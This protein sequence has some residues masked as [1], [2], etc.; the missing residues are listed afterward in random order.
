[1]AVIIIGGEKGGTGKSTVSSNISIMLSLMGLD[2]ALIDCDKQRSATRAL[3]HRNELQIKPS[4]SCIQLSGKHIYSE[5][6]D[7]TKRFAHLIIDTGGRDS[8]EL[9][10]A[11]TAKT[12]TALYS[13]FQPSAFD[14][15]T[16][17]VMDKIIE[18]AMI[19]N[20]SLQAYSF[21]NRASTNTKVTTTNDAIELLEGAMNIKY[22][23]RKLSERV[24]FQHA[25]TC[26]LSVVEYERQKIMEMPQY[27]NSYTPKASIEICDLF[28]TIMG[29]PFDYEK[30]FKTPL[31][32][33][34]TPSIAA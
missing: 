5:I 22:S 18:H 25:R 12:L 1:M 13:P 8:I 15:E 27:R 32:K 6:E 24:P 9:R 7:L 28:N 11:M 14:L 17:E 2:S 34:E 16:L 30:V 33:S 26:G 19:Y 10:S 20:P 31:I 4:P 29:F 21:I 3:E 23:G